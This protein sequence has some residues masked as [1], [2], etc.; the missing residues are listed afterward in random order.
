[1]RPDNEWAR[2]RGRGTVSPETSIYGCKCV[3]NQRA[4]PEFQALELSYPEN[5][6]SAEPGPGILNIVIASGPQ[7]SGDCQDDLDWVNGDVARRGHMRGHL[8]GHSER[9]LGGRRPT[10]A[11]T[12]SSSSTP[13]C[14]RS[15]PRSDGLHQPRAN[16]GVALR[17]PDSSTTD[18]LANWPCAATYG[19]SSPEHPSAWTPGDMDLE[20]AARP[21]GRRRGRSST[22]PGRRARPLG[23]PRHHPGGRPATGA[24]GRGDRGLRSLLRAGGHAPGPG[25]ARNHLLRGFD[26]SPLC[27][28]VCPLRV[29]SR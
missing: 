11:T 9:I 18:E 13:T 19:G 22:W 4:A 28:R 8:G 26:V 24:P 12:A 16:G 29:T 15:R 3:S 6:K 1:M 17:R 20:L 25:D 2:A 21:S 7:S 10:T 27:P 23:R 14:A 5:G